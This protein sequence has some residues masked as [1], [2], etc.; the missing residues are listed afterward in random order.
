MINKGELPLVLFKTKENEN[1]FCGNFK[2]LIQCVKNNLV[3]YNKEVINEK[4]L[5]GTIID[6]IKKYNKQ[7]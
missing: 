3:D 7:K 6:E 4:Y 1:I 2:E 5:I